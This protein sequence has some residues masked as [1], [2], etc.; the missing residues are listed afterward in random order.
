MP[1]EMLQ[2]NIDEITSILIDN[3]CELI[4]FEKG[5]QVKYTCLCKNIV[6]TNSSNIRRKGLDG[7][8]KC[9]KQKCNQEINN[10]I[11]ESDG[12]INLSQICKAGKNIMLIGFD[13]KKQKSF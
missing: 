12:Y 6:E 3:D 10:F 7:C 2:K 8:A 5:Y 9:S 11:R 4:S 13:Q 1:T